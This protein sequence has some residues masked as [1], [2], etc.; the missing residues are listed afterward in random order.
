MIFDPS[1]AKGLSHYFTLSF[2]PSRGTGRGISTTRPEF[3]TTT[4]RKCRG[5]W[6][7]K[8]N[9][10]RPFVPKMPPLYCHGT[11]SLRHKKTL[12]PAKSQIIQIVHGRHCFYCSPWRGCG[13]FKPT[14]TFCCT[15][16]ELSTRMRRC[17]FPPRIVLAVKERRKESTRVIQSTSHAKMF[18]EWY[19]PINREKSAFWVD[20]IVSFNGYTGTYGPQTSV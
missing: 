11:F 1:K 2:D 15:F 8:A 18:D 16:I 10:P 6:L 14:R 17:S 12:Y 19:D 20:G 4:K 13:P 5:C 9:L 3:S 7:A